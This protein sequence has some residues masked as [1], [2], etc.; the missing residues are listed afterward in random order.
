M[1]HTFGATIGLNFVVILPHKNGLV[2]A[3]RFAHI[4]IDAFGGDHQGHD[5]KTK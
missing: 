2:G 1:A 5:K 3:F 4:T